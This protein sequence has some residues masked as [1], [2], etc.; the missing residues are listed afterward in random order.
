MVMALLGLLAG[1]VAPRLGTWYTSVQGAYQRDE[2]L[3]QLAGLGYLAY[4]DQQEWVLNEWPL[5]SETEAANATAEAPPLALPAG[6]RLRAEPPLRYYRS[7]VCGGGVV[8]LET[9][10]ET[11]HLRLIPP[12]CRPEPV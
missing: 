7:G 9:P 3:R 1:L 4:R 8:T 11:L 2:A 12:F 5:P 6:W 10:V